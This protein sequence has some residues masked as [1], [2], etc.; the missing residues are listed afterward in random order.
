MIEAIAQECA[1]AQKREAFS[2]RFLR[3]ASAGLDKEKETWTLFFDDPK[4]IDR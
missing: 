1:A 3:K 2:A 4:D